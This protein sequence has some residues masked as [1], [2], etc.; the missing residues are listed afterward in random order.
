MD[1]CAL[2]YNE[3]TPRPDCF[4][5]TNMRCAAQII[6]ATLAV[7]AISVAAERPTAVRGSSSAPITILV[8]SDFESFPCA[9]SA[10]VI[11][12]LLQQTRDVR[13]I[14]KHAPA[15]S[16]PNAMLAHEAALAG[17]AQGKFWEMHNLLFENQTK[18]TRADLLVY[19]KSLG[20]DL[21]AFQ[22]ALD[23]HT[24]RPIVERDLA[25][26]AG[27]GVT[28]TPTFFVNGRRLVGPQGYASLGAVIESLLAGVPPD[29]RVQAELVA[30]GP[31][32]QIDLRSAPTRGPATAPVSL[33]EFSDFE[34]PY[35]AMA[36]P[37][38]KQLLAAY[39]AQVRFAFKHYPLPMHKESPLAHEAALAAGEQGK[40]WE[41]HDAL[42][43]ETAGTDRQRAGT[44]ERERGGTDGTVHAAQEPRLGTAVSVP[45][46]REDLIAKAKQ[47]N[48][49]VP[50]FTRDLDS[51]RFKPQVDADRQEG[52][53]LGVDGTPFFFING[54]AI[55]GGASLAD[56]KHLIDAALKESTSTPVR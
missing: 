28:T 23:N 32:Q 50:R 27:L 36:A 30:A 44:D 45:F 7:A 54:H 14:F 21:A 37:V 11:D 34:C 4:N 42:F 8:F 15:A 13:V 56:F 1:F 38:V 40:F 9:R 12:G 33:V 24:Y 5:D 16:N 20:L 29:K 43:A 39:P 31:A 10:S 53:R 48:L 25:E 6:A 17:G 51:H 52:N 55:S 46:T 41:M 19:A 2:Q 49:D 26:A 47:L 18:L 3:R 35:C 22:H